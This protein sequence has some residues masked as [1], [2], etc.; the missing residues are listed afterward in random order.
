MA[1]T[2]VKS[3]LD[4]ILEGLNEDPAHIMGN[5]NGRFNAAA[6]PYK[7]IDRRSSYGWNN[8]LIEAATQTSDRKAVTLVDYDFNRTISVIGRRTLMSLARSMIWRIPPLWSAIQ[9]QANLAVCP[10]TPIY[11]GKNKDWGEQALEWL[12]NW[13]DIQDFAAWPYDGDSY[14]ELLITASIV[15]GDIFTLLTETDSGSPRTQL[16]PSH[17]V[18]SRYQSSSVVKVRYEGSSLFVDEVPIDESLPFTYSQAVEFEAQQIDGVI[19]DDLS[20]PIAYR[21]YDDP[22]V[23]S[24]YQDISARNL[25]PSFLPVIAG[26]V[27]NVSLLAS[28]IFDWQDV[29]EFKRFELLAQKTFSSKT[30]VETNETGDIDTSKAV[31]TAP[32]EFDNSGNKT[33]LD[34]MQLDGGAYHVFKANTGSKLEAFDWKDRPG[35]NAQDFMEMSIREAMTGIEWSSF[36]GVDPAHVG[37]APMRVI[38]DRVNRTL[39]KRRKLV[40]KSR[41]RVDK[42][43]IAKAMKAGDLP[44]DVDWFRWDYRGPS[45]VT[46]D[47]EYDVISD[48]MEYRMGWITG[49][50]LQA[51]RNGNLT[52]KRQKRYEEAQQLYTKAKQLSDEFGISVQEAAD[53]L[54][55]LGTVSFAMARRDSGD[56]A[57]ATDAGGGM[58]QDKTGKKGNGNGQA[59]APPINL[60]I[61]NRAYVP[62]KKIKFTKDIRGIIT[63]AE[64]EAA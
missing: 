47:R 44:F 56:E 36:F 19:M 23:S 32:A 20:R 39:R 22:S 17:R 16:I 34:V 1:K 28:S 6:A 60:N 11:T 48:Q 64:V 61:E 10:F 62:K 31:V 58:K 9:E 52:Q 30:I 53:R 63:G 54:E 42:Y 8:T 37:G 12:L 26:Q 4:I 5:G 38:V 14:N 55:Q 18:G 35:R 40:K 41:L 24:N 21:V 27:R 43:A 7:I 49:E 33:K 25:F 15:D 45:D 51:R 13:Y 29:R 46:A 50:D 2:K 57:L 59:E 3:S